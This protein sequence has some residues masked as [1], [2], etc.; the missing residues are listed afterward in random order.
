MH[1]YFYRMPLPLTSF[2]IEKH[3]VC[4]VFVFAVRLC[5]VVQLSCCLS[6]SSY[7]VPSSEHMQMYSEEGGSGRLRSAVAVAFVL[8][9]VMIPVMP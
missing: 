4:T 2:F 3:V 9:S 8:P 5:R 1:D 6:A 7:S